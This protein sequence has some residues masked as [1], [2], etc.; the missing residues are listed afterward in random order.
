VTDRSRL[1]SW[2]R[3]FLLEHMIGERNLSRNTQASYRDT[4]C[5]L[6]PFAVTR[7]SQAVDKLTVDNLSADCIRAFLAHLEEVR[8][9]SVS[10]R[11][12]RLA[13]IHAL[14]RFIGERSP[15]HV[16]WCSQVRA[17]PF[18]RSEKASL[19]Y[20]EKAELDALLGAPNQHTEQGRRDH[21]V[22]LFLYNSGAR[23]SEATRV[24]IAD[25]HR[26][27][28]G[29]GFVKLHGKGRKDRSCPLWPKT[30]AALIPLAGNRPGSTSLFVNCRGEPLTRFGIHT[31]VER[32]A[33]A[34]AQQLPS[35]RAKRVSP[36]TIRHTTA[37][38][39]LRAGV[40]INT[41]RAWLGHVSLD[42]THV[43]AETD[44]AMKA[45]ALAACDPGEDIEKPRRK[46]RGDRELMQFLRNL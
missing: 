23:A 15:E 16:E 29:G 3:R 13:A 11:N 4:L 46:W 18:K 28:A 25:L 38:H 34:A 6:L 40:D 26:E 22:L 43:Y 32:H 12:Q 20:L 44:L 41:I 33:R 7:C 31:L 30:M 27:S 42:T 19:S 9:C 37:T 39:L 2:V 14:A 35:L 21:A 1:G 36:H 8:R 10:T 5:L 24:T 17:V 45:K